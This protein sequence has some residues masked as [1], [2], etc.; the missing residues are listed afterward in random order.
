MGLL[1]QHTVKMLRLSWRS[2][3][4]WLRFLPTTHPSCRCPCSHCI[5]TQQRRVWSGANKFPGGSAPCGVTLFSPVTSYKASAL[6]TSYPHQDGGTKKNKQTFS[7]PRQY[8]RPPR[9]RGGVM[10]QWVKCF[11][12]QHKDLGSILSALVLKKKKKRQI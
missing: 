1:F 9:R 5:G 10:A 2:L 11:V 12:V 7:P 3:R 4:L 6:K 8:V